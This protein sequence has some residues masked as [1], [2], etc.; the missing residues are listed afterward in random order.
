MMRFILCLVGCK[1]VTKQYTPPKLSKDNGLLLFSFNCYR[2][3]INSNDSCLY[4]WHIRPHSSH[5]FSP[6]V[7]CHYY[8]RR[9]IQYIPWK[10]RG[11]VKSINNK[12]VLHFSIYFSSSSQRYFYIQTHEWFINR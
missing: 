11:Y 7:T 5:S 1:A 6:T 2:P 3:L 10:I 4:M 8:F 12:F 9:I